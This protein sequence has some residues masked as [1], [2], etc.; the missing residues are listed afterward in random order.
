MWFPKEGDRT[1]TLWTYDSFEH[2]ANPFWQTFITYNIGHCTN[3]PEEEE[4][5]CWAA[6]LPR[7]PMGIGAELEP[8]VGTSGT[9]FDPCKHSQDKSHAIFAFEVHFAISYR[10]M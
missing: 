6:K 4:L 7:P 8:S 9:C 3:V 5:F 2:F 10:Q 1:N